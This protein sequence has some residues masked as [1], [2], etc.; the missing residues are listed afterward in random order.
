MAVSGARSDA[1]L[2]PPGAQTP[3]AVSALHR[4]QPFVQPPAVE[5]NRVASLL[6]QHT[7]RQHH[8]LAGNWCWKL[9][10][11]L[12]SWLLNQVFRRLYSQLFS[13]L[14]FLISMGY[15]HLYLV[16]VAVLHSSA[17]RL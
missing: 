2:K 11:W 8:L 3:N 1:K 17:E 16:G 13:R 5:S 7:K 14:L 4:T 9:L 10:S 6:G 15:K 12:F